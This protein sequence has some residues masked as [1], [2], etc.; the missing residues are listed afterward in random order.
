MTKD[1]EDYKERDVYKELVYIICNFLIRKRKD[2]NC[3]TLGLPIKIKLREFDT[4]FEYTNQ[5]TEELKIKEIETALKQ[6]NEDPFNESGLTA[7]T[8][9]DTDV[10]TDFF[11]NY[12]K[13]TE[14][15]IR[16]SVKSLTGYM[17]RLELNTP[18]WKVLEK[19]EAVKIKQEKIM[20]KISGIARKIY[21]DIELKPRDG[22]GWLQLKKGEKMINMGS[23][24][25]RTYKMIKY[26]LAPTSKSKKI[27]DVFE[28]IRIKNDKK[29]QD[30][31]EN[32]PRSHQR[33]KEIILQSII[34]LQKEKYLKGRVLK[35]IFDDTDKT[36]KI[37]FQ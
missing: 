6:L 16:C 23:Y 36:V 18:K 22:K 31:S 27:I 33:K 30:L 29:N 25:T 1:F 21:P 13:N 8:I 3:R 7:I 2:P 17:E 20:F 34:E 26:I 28:E 9:E 32:T 12:I 35:P 37:V 5:S 11:N 4:Y 10:F 14:I 15:I 19:V 24:E